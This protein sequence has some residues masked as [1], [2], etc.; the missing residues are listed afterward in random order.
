ME[1]PALSKRPA[2]ACRL[3]P[4]TQVNEERIPGLAT[5]HGQ[6]QSFFN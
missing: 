4:L 1:L 6:E 2:R 3:E 5:A